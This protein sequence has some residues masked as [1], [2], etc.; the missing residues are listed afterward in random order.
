MAVD[1]QR[2]AP[3]RFT[4]GKQTRYPLYW[5][6][7]G[8]AWAGTEYLAF[9]GTSRPWRRA[10]PAHHS[11]MASDVEEQPGME[12]ANSSARWIQFGS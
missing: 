9:T 5:K 7:T 2:H 12:T 3:S 11:T 8:R 6:T 10:I 1:G 4:L